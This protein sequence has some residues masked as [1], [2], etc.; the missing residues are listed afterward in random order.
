MHRA[1][2]GRQKMWKQP[3]PARNARKPKRRPT[4]LMGISERMMRTPKR[5][6]KKPLSRDDKPIQWKA[7]WFYVKQAL[8]K[9]ITEFSTD[10]PSLA[11]MKFG[12]TTDVNRLAVG[13]SNP[14]YKPCKGWQMAHT[15]V[16]A[17]GN[18]ITLR[19]VP[20]GDGALDHFNAP[21]GHRDGINI[22]H[23]SAPDITLVKLAWL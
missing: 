12:L 20:G 5:N 17:F 21:F 11:K 15:R 10:L 8:E 9:W 1:M 4:Q 7:A 19:F 3:L 13:D 6:S 23:F 18:G 16:I 22:A 14:N 2:Q